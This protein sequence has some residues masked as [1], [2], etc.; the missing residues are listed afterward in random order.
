MIMSG[1]AMITIGEYYRSHKEA[2]E[3]SA[4]DPQSAVELQKCP[5]VDDDTVLLADIKDD[6]SSFS[7][8]LPED[9]ESPQALALISISSPSLPID[10]AVGKDSSSFIKLPSIWNGNS[11]SAGHEYSALSSIEDVEQL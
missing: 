8:D 10:V 6:D 2:K 11:Q 7:D 3:I 1:V 5:S 4:N 9:V